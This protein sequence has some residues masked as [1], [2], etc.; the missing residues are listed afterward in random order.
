MLYSVQAAPDTGSG[1]LSEWT[2]MNVARGVLAMLGWFIVSLRLH[3]DHLSKSL[4]KAND[5]ILQPSTGTAKPQTTA[6]ND[7]LWLTQ[8]T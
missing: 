5:D 3:T 6:R 4:L 1:W 8:T 2:G 7:S